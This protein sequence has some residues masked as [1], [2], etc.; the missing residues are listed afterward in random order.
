MKVPVWFDF[1]MIVLS[2]MTYV[3]LLLSNEVRDYVI[4]HEKALQ[5]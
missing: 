5:V 3:F 4:S 2:H 1:L